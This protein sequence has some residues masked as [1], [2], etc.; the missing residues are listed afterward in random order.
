MGV[1]LSESSVAFLREMAAWYRQNRGR[2]GTINYR[3]N[4]RL[5]SGAA[6]AVSAGASSSTAQLATVVVAP[7][8]EIP[9]TATPEV[10][11]Y[12]VRLITDTTAAYNAVT[13][14]VIGNAVIAATN[15]RR[16]VS[17]TGTIEV[18][19]VGNEPSVSPTDWE[20][21]EEIKIEYVKYQ[22][23]GDEN[24]PY[25]LLNCAPQYRVGDEVVITNRVVG[26]NTIW[27]ID[28]TFTHLGL[29]ENASGRWDMDNN[30]FK[31]VFR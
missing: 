20:V 19:N 26:E 9:E 15:G 11:Y 31:A 17:L 25:S 29:P 3:R 21:S 18:P 12:I 14:Y 7:A 30:Q 8:Y 22:N 24:T 27:Y 23:F 1:L 2:L 16:Y 4:P 28:E 13:G 6:P 5:Q 10:T